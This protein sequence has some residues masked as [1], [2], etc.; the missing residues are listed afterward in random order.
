MRPSQGLWPTG[1]L[2]S[3][4]GVEQQGD[5]QH[6]FVASAQQRQRPV[7]GDGLDWFGI[8]V[9]VAEFR[10]IGFLAFDYGRFHH[11]VRFQVF[12]QCAEE[13]CIFGELF[14][15]NLARPVEHG[16]DV[17]KTGVGVDE[18]LGFGFRF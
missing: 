1:L 5:L 11:A 9:V 14:H 18:A 4:L 2:A 6:A 17:G 8:V 10:A 13:W 16:L 7:R 3:K 12:T 15:E